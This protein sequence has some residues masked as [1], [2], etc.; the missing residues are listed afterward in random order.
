MTEAVRK[1]NFMA[2]LLTGLNHRIRR[3]HVVFVAILLAAFLTYQYPNIKFWFLS[4]SATRSIVIIDRLPK[5]RRYYQL[6]K[7]ETKTLIGLLRRETSRPG[8]ET[9]A[10]H[11]YVCVYLIDDHGICVAAVGI[12]PSSWVTAKNRKPVSVV[13]EIFQLSH[14][15]E[16]LEGNPTVPQMDTAPYLER[17]HY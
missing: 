9:K 16:Q 10:Y 2:R 6:S 8:Y 15:W 4:R 13:A 5:D 1:G 7:D 11:M 14:N 17:V 3:S 12:R